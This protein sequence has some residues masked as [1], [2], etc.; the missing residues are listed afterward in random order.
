[1]KYTKII[2]EQF[3]NNAR[4]AENFKKVILHTRVHLIIELLALNLRQYNKATW[5]D[6]CYILKFSLKNYITVLDP[7]EFI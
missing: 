7:S 3:T 1:M 2:P 5:N 4:P 6:M